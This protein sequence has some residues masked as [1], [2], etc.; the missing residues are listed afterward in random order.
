MATSCTRRHSDRDASPARAARGGTPSGQA[1]SSARATTLRL[2]SVF[3]RV[4]NRVPR[5]EER[6]E[7]EPGPSPAALPL[8]GLAVL[9]LAGCA[10]LESPGGA[11][12][13]QF[14]STSTVGGWKYDPT[15]TP[16]IRAAISGYQTFVIGTKV[17]SSTG[18]RAPLWMLMHGGGVGWFA[19]NG[20]PQPSA[21]KKNEEAAAAL[22]RGSPP[23]ALVGPSATTRRAS[24]SCRSRCAATTSTPAANSRTRTTRTPR[25]TASRARSTGCSPRRRPSQFAQ[26]KYPT[27]KTSCT[28]TSAGSVGTFD[29]AWSHA[30]R[31][32]AARPGRRGRGRASTRRWRRRR[33]QGVCAEDAGPGAL[34]RVAARVHPDLANIDNELDKLVASGRP[35]GARPA[36]LEPRRRQHAAAPCRWS[37]R[38]RDGSHGRRWASRTACTSRCSRRSP[39]RARARGRATCASA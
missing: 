39:P 8:V 18:R 3:A 6:N 32:H 36:R 23:A 12:Q 7:P 35:H 31:G 28:A 24:A 33:S 26:Q 25:P 15:A 34:G 38:C 4:T 2:G 11:G 14:V 5:L 13:I 19:P 21:G 10:P 29:V 30:A 1:A 16:R 22:D 20:T 27:S 17:G 37:A 9:A